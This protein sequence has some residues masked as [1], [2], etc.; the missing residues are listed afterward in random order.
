MCLQVNISDF[1]DPYDPEIRAFTLKGQFTLKWLLILCLLE[2]G[3]QQPN[4]IY[5]KTPEVQSRTFNVP[6]VIVTPPS[7]TSGRADD[8]GS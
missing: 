3:A 8:Q 2:V 4:A 7:Q 6:A 5:V 1:A